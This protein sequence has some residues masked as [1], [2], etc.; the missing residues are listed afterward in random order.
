MLTRSNSKKFWSSLCAF[1]FPPETAELSRGQFD[2]KPTSQLVLSVGQSA[3]W[4]L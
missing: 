2:F 1:A 3:D 4:E